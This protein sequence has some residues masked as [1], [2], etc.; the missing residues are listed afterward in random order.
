MNPAEVMSTRIIT[1]TEKEIAKTS[2]QKKGTVSLNIEV[3]L[4]V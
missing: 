4:H 3:L 1:K 2:M